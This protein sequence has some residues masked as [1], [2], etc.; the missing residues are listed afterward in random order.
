MLRRCL[1]L[2]CFDA[3]LALVVLLALQYFPLPGVVLMMFGAAALAGQLVHLV[4]ASLFI[5]AL[6]GRVPRALALVPVIAYGGYYAVW[7]E[8]GRQ[9]A[10]VSAELRA[11]NPGKIYDFD[12]TRDALVMKEAQLFVE[13]HDIP[14][15]YE[16][17]ANFPEGALSER[18]IPRSQCSGIRRDTQNRVLTFGV[19]FNNVFQN[20]ICL[21]RFPERPA[22]RMVTAT[23]RGDPEIWAHH[24]DIRRQTTEISVD[25]EIVGS[26]T[27][28]FAWRLPAFPNLA[29]GCALNDA[30]PSWDC[31]A[32]F[33][34]SPMPIDGIP[35]SVDKARF[36]GPVSVLLGIRRYTA[37][38]LAGFAGFESNA[39]AL[40]QAHEEPEQVQ[41]TVFDALASIIDGQNPK[42]PFNLGYSLAANPERLAPLAEGMTRRFVA[43]VGGDRNTPYRRE[44]IEALAVAIGALPH[45][46]LAPVA[47]ALL[48]VISHDP[49]ARTAY[50]MVYVRVAEAG[51]AALPFYRDQFMGETAKGWQR[52]FPAL[53]LCR[54]GEADAA[55]IEE[56]KK[57]YLAV[58]LDGGGDPVNYKSALFVALLK[59]GQEDFLRADHPD[60]PG[61]DDWYAQVLAGAGLTRTGPNN[62]MPEDWGF[63]IYATPA[64]APSLKW[65]RGAWEARKA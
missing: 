59:L 55:L 40:D 2:V 33:I 9:I 7:F 16:P 58:D 38:D 24:A 29:I 3:L 54:I 11:A 47:G 23:L 12:P 51:A 32:D 34:R 53:A 6:I 30:R 49:R 42:P 26:F 37:A 15:V 31:F 39:A 41:N 50:P 61:R 45:E 60:K 19:Q 52:M 17:S 35:D 46:A 65:R 21:L 27:T 20:N 36:D 62:C 10:Q 5:E 14:V 56:M 28:A 4:L 57:R 25:G 43:L 44:Q 18:L 1:S 13:A 48:D 22:N 63:T 64:V 8:Q